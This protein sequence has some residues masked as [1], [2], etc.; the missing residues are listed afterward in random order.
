MLRKSSWV[1]VPAKE[2]QLDSLPSWVTTTFSL[3][4]LLSNSALLFL[5]WFPEEQRKTSI[6]ST[7][8]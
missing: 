3:I 4:H 2:F 8:R 5:I 1:L 6:P 7:S